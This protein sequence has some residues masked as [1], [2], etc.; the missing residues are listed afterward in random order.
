MAICC[1]DS[2][3]VLSLDCK[4]SAN[5]ILD[6]VLTLIVYEVDEYKALLKYVAI[7]LCG[8]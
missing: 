3:C 1:Y 4:F 7:I 6:H 8:S 5:V 2:I